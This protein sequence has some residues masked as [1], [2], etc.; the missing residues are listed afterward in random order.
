MKGQP[1]TNTPPRCAAA[2]A[3][4]MRGAE[5][6]L[7]RKMEPIRVKGWGL[8][9]LACNYEFYSEVRK[10]SLFHNPW[11]FNIAMVRNPKFES[12]RGDDPTCGIDNRWSCIWIYHAAAY[13]YEPQLPH[14]ALGVERQA[15][16]PMC[17]AG[18]RKI[19]MMQHRAW[20]SDPASRAA[21]LRTNPGYLVRLETRWNS[22]DDLR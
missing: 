20:R 7:R 14:E 11:N 21:V 5:P 1:G 16:M 10:N 17:I 8:Y 4:T 2:A 15:D 19:R 6:A 12:D 13:L 18:W 22:E 3:D 9:D